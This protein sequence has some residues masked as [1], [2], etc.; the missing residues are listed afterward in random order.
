[1]LKR[2]MAT[3][4]TFFMLATL[5]MGQSANIF[6]ADDMLSLAQVEA[7]LEEIHKN[8]ARLW[9]FAVEGNP[10][11]LRPSHFCAESLMRIAFDAMRDANSLGTLLSLSSKMETKADEAVLND[12]VR[13]AMEGMIGKMHDYQ[14]PIKNKMNECKTDE[15]IVG[16]GKTILRIF[17][18][19][20]EL[21][22]ELGDRM[23]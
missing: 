16:T 23:K 2:Q 7:K 14:L 3:L 8:L 9:F 19:A 4:F 6:K 12:E 20:E 18:E 5:P 17:A 22:Q 11:P 10:N 15:T 1:M 21:I 13:T